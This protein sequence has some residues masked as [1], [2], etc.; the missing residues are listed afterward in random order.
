METQTQKQ[1]R[2]TFLT[3]VC[4]ISFVGLGLS[5]MNNL[6]N[7][8]FGAFGSAVYP[9]I[10]DAFEQALNE[11]DASDP[12]ATIF[13]EQIFNAVLELLEILPILASITL[14]LTIVALIGVIM[15][16]NLNKTGFYLYSGSKVVIIFI[17][18]IL[19]GANFISTMIVISGIFFA[20]LFIT[21]YALNL[22]AMK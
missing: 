12:G 2:P 7:I 4:I 5:I 15:M 19:M 6:G 20:G 14:A 13:V 9:F 1:A 21:M 16:W 10:Q 22:K 18:M 3:V 8:G 11:V 17:P